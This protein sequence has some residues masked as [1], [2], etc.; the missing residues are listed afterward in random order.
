[1]E[2]ESESAM[3][4]VGVDASFAADHLPLEYRSIHDAT[5]AAAANDVGNDKFL[6][7]AIHY[8]RFFIDKQ[9]PK[10]LRQ[11]T[12]NLLPLLRPTQ[13]VDVTDADDHGDDGGIIND[14][15]S[16]LAW[17]HDAF[18][19][20]ERLPDE[21]RD[22]FDW[23]KMRRESEYAAGGGGGGGF[24]ISALSKKSG[25]RRAPNFDAAISTIDYRPFSG[26]SASDRRKLEEEKRRRL[27][28]EFQNVDQFLDHFLLGYGMAEVALPEMDARLLS[29]GGRRGGALRMSKTAFG[30]GGGAVH[31]K[32]DG[33]DDN[34]DDRIV[35]TIINGV[36]GSFKEK[37]GSSLTSVAKEN[38]RWISLLHQSDATRFEAEAFQRILT[39]VVNSFEKSRFGAGAE[40]STTQGGCRYECVWWG[41]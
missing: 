9:T 34:D 21:W 25:F 5:S 4:E 3:I 12:D 36:P 13:K 16:H 38:A 26:E 30:V 17:R 33:D 27:R 19:C 2:K 39:S 24:S 32:G 10:G 20:L 8:L 22:D 23:L 31:G 18:E 28:M 37:L 35:L 29:H 6:G 7:K 1:M 14:E 40:A 41:C 15:E 11:V